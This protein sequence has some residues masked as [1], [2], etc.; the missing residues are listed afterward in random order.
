[1]TI[2]IYNIVHKDNPEKCYIGSSKKC[3]VRFTKH[4]YNIKKNIKN[5]KVYQEIRADGVENY[6]FEIIEEVEDGD[7][8]LLREK[9]Q[10]YI[11]TYKPSLNSINAYQTPEE[12][13]EKKRKAWT[14]RNKINVE[15]EC[16]YK[17]LK[18]HIARHKKTKRHKTIMI[19]KKIQELKDLL[20]DDKNIII[21]HEDTGL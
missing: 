18:A 4:K 12:L 15:C 14:I 10:H 3:E 11:S 6:I 20:G 21:T 19:N 9:E 13:Y 1:M 7:E 2:G 16:G 17:G 5:Y 8:M